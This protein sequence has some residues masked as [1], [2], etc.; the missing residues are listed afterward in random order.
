MKNFDLLM[1]PRVGFHEERLTKTTLSPT[2]AKSART[3]GW[4]EFV[5]R[6]CKF[7]ASTGHGET[8]H[9][10]PKFES[11]RCARNHLNFPTKVSVAYEQFHGIGRPVCLSSR[12]TAFAATSGHSIIGLAKLARRTK[13]THSQDIGLR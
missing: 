4:R 11:Y 10:L 8:S 1:I 13:S 2:E 3:H 7:V 5:L 6:C 12:M 9:A